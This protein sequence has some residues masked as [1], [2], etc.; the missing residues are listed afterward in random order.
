M[1]LLKS[2]ALLI[3]IFILSSC[4]GGSE[5]APVV[6]GVKVQSIQYG[7]T[8][9]IYIGGKDLRSTLNVDTSGS[10]V[11]SSYASNSTTDMLVFNCL[12][13]K[14]GDMPFVIKTAEGESIYSTSVNVPLPQVVL[15]TSKGALTFELVDPAVAP[16]SVNNFLNYVNKGF[17]RDTLFH[18]VIPG[19]V[20]QGGGFTVG[21]VKKSGQTAPI[22]LESNRGLSNLRGSLAMA[23]APAPNSAQSEFYINLVDNLSLD[24]RNAANPGYA[25][26]GRVIQ[27]LDIIDTI[28][29]VPTG[30]VNGFSNVPFEDIFINLALQ[31]K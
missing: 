23:R 9:T 13:S 1:R 21:M 28:S 24:Y 18:R 4:G 2:T 15:I 19:F 29:T 22:E 25:V 16:S 27:G 5:F 26:F 17:Y 31:I 12:V 30:I 11:N 6:T 3:T 20:V 14:T 7:R 10:C 8:A